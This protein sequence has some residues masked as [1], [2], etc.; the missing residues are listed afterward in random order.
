MVAVALT[1]FSG[2]APLFDPRLLPESMAELA[3]NLDV[4][5]GVLDGF[6]VPAAEHVF[7]G[8]YTKA[9]R[10]PNPGG[11]AF[12]WLGLES[13]Y[14]S[15][16]RSPLANDTERRVYWTYPLAQSAFWSTYQRIVD[17]DPPYNL[18]TVHPSET[19]PLT[20]TTSGGSGTVYATRSYCFTYV[21][22]YGEESRPNF[23]S[24]VVTAQ[25]D[26]T[27]H[28]SGLPTTPPANPAGINYPPVTRI[29]LYRTLSG[30]TT[31]GAFFRLDRFDF[32]G[33]EF[34]VPPA[35]YDDAWSDETIVANQVLESSGWGNPPE[36]LDGL[37]AI[38]GG[39]LVG[40]VA[41][42]VYMTEPNRPHAWPAAYD[43]SLHYDIVGLTLW[44]QS[45]VAVTKGY[46][47][48]GSGTTPSTFT[49][50]QI[51]AAAPCIARGS[52]VTDL[53]G[54]YYASTNGLVQLTSS[55]VANVTSLMFSPSEWITD[56][57]ARDVMA[58]RH[59]GQY[60]AMLTGE[61]ILSAISPGGWMLDFSPQK[62]GVTRVESF[63]AVTAIWNDAD[64]GDTYVMSGNTVYRWDAYDSAHK[65]CW[66]WKSK[67]LFRQWP[68]NFGAVQIM[69]HPTIET[70]PDPGYVPPL[71][72]PDDPDT[73]LPAGV[74]AT[75]TVTASP[76]HSFTRN[77]SLRQELFRLPSG[78]RAFDWQVEI[79]SRVPVYSIELGSTMHE[80]RTVPYDA[81]E[82]ARVRAS[83]TIGASQKEDPDAV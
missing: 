47:S 60:L 21:N 9:Y 73:L 27:F 11:T 32:D 28:V 17:G 43:Q 53:S 50:R 8:D 54:V 71:H 35:T 64:T 68:C 18:G 81:A 33:V 41:N 42:T 48:V 38:P 76:G 79:I 52:I 15:V 69:A 77:L 31:G 4:S 20:V 2:M 74:N 10:L 3:V 34:P 19:V 56:Y 59:R 61:S 30:T 26:A 1:K 13:R 22:D 62:H 45:L 78:F 44:N 36:F 49:F 66:R 75:V 65:L 63:Q 37:T 51:Q 29:H 12:A 5:S 16:A 46:P 25:A 39:M 70:P 72:A 67:L 40:F 58:C 55:G 6:R 82:T 7:S 14:A 23:P 24:P 57:V 83:Q 80:L